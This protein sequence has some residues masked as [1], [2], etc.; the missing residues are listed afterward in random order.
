[1]TAAVGAEFVTVLLWSALHELERAPALGIPEPI[2][3]VL[4]PRAG[5]TVQ[6]ISDPLDHLLLALDRCDQMVSGL[7]WVV[8]SPIVQVPLVRLDFAIDVFRVAHHS[9]NSMGSRYWTGLPVAFAYSISFLVDSPMY[10]C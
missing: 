7:C 8:V 10:P 9:S 1:M 6:R 5:A 4:R 3:I 2:I